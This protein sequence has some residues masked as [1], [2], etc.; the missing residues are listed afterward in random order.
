MSPFEIGDLVRDKLTMPDG[1]YGLGIVVSVETR[2]QYLERLEKEGRSKIGDY[3]NI[4]SG[5]KYGV[6]FTQFQR[7]ITFHGDYLERV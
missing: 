5:K 6:Y 7:T 1:N 4:K 3:D 2:Q